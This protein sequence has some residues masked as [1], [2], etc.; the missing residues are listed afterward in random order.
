MG[1]G[2]HH[3]LDDCLYGIHLPRLPWH[4][5][6]LPVASRRGS[7][8][9]F[10]EDVTIGEKAFKGCKNLNNVNF[11]RVVGIGSSAFEGCTSFYELNLQA[12]RY[13]DRNA[14]KDCK[15]LSNIYLSEIIEM[16]SPFTG[17]NSITY[18][19]ISN[20]GIP[21]SQIGNFDK[22]ETLVVKENYN[23][24]YLVTNFVSGLKSL[25]F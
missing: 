23:Y 15:S 2:Y 24:N 8:V 1:D 17:D 3:A 7:A 10:E 19:T 14:F 13:L 25:N 20:Y 22:L 21:M 12:V 6:D 5:L 16:D 11:D 4:L 18:L 9:Y